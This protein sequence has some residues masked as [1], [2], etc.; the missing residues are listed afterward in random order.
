[1]PIREAHRDEFP[2]IWPFFREIVAAGE[3]FPYPQDT[4]FEDGQRKWFDET[5]KVFVFEENGEI[6]GTYA[7]KPNSP[8]LGGHVCNCGYMVSPAARG[9][10]VAKALCVHS[11]ETAVALGYRAMQYNLVVSTNEIA[12]QLWQKMG[13]TIAGTLPKAFQHPAHG[14]VDAY[15]M[16]KWLT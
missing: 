9:R 6:L 15:V 12:V 8:G 4:T 14:F 1:M 3:S 7:I 11:Q 16:Y 10:G 13:F 5:E 2:A